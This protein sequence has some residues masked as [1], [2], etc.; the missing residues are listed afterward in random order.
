MMD[1]GLVKQLTG[2]RYV[3]VRGNYA[4]N[5]DLKIEFTLLMLANSL[6][7]MRDDDQGIWRRMRGRELASIK[8]GRAHV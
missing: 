3:N 5:E 8:I 1:T 2:D 6:P 4:N 7:R